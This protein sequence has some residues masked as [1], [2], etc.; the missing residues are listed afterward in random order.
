MTAQTTADLAYADVRLGIKSEQRKAF[1]LLSNIVKAND[2]K[3][4]AQ[5]EAD[6]RELLRRQASGEARGKEGLS[7]EALGGETAPPP[8]SKL[9]PHLAPNL[10]DHLNH[11][12]LIAS[13]RADALNTVTPVAKALYQSLSP[14]QR[15]IAD[16]V[17]TFPGL[18]LL[19]PPPGEDHREGHPGE[20]GP[21]REGPRPS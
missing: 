21:H 9:S 14:D 8:P 1:D 7:K 18:L 15:Q 11:E 3:A 17:L 13:L 4:Q 20:E 2:A 5:C 16:V 10:I 12:T 19:P 6:Q